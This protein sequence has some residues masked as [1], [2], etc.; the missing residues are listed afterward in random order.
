MQPATADQADRILTREARVLSCGGQTRGAATLLAHSCYP[1][2]APLALPV[3]APL[4]HGPLS[5]PVVLDLRTGQVI[6]LKMIYSQYS[7]RMI[8]AALL[9]LL[10]A[11]C[12]R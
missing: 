7:P 1:L 12:H 11:C 6:L 3:S 4:F 8:W 10:V 5:V 2:A 9:L